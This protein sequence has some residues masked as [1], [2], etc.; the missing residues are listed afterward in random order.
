M[1]NDSESITALLAEWH[2]LQE[3]LIAARVNEAEAATKATAAR[4]VVIAA[5]KDEAVAWKALDA[6]RLRIRGVQ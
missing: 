6:E 2:R 4:N 5:E 3:I 1:R